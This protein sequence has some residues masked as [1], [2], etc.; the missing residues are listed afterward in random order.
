MTVQDYQWLQ[1]EVEVAN[2]RVECR[3][4]VFRWSSLVV[5][6]TILAVT[7]WVTQ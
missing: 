2:G 6:A 5:L 4:W 3:A 1:R 7:W